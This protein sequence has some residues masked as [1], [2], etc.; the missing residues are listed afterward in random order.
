MSKKS[1][2]ANKKPT[3]G[4]LFKTML[5]NMFIKLPE[6]KG[7]WFKCGDTVFVFTKD[8]ELLDTPDY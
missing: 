2:Q 5:P 7:F 3:L 1:N 4:L 6:W 8:G